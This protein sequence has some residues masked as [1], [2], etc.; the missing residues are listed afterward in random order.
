M[1]RT[2][3]Y[4][5]RDNR[6][7]G[8]VVTFHN[9]TQLKNVEEALR[10]SEFKLRRLFESD[11]IGILFAEGETITDANDVFLKMVGYTREDL[12]AG[13]INWRAMTPPE[14]RESDDRAVGG[15]VHAGSCAPFEKEYLRKDGSRVP[16]VLG[17]ARLE[18]SPLRW[19]CFVF[20]ISERR[21]AEQALRES[22]ERLSLAIDAAHMGSFD[23][24]LAT[25]EILWTPYHEIIFGY[26]PGTPRRTYQD[27]ASRVHPED[28]PRVEECFEAKSGRS[29][30][31]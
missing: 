27:F 29:Q 13:R 9:V 10:Q 25:N 15:V 3:P 5:T 22:E 7:E 21:E 8:V 26:P 20:D 28:L 18:R 12:A 19:V 31:L 14:Y 11:L 23:W 30:A 24:N 16:I 4:R 17:A 2:L 1:R 6:I